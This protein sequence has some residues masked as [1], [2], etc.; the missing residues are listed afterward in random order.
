MLYRNEKE[1]LLLMIPT[2]MSQALSF[3]RKYEGILSSFFF[4]FLFLFLL[5][6]LFLFLFLFLVLFLLFF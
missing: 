1:T 2:C 5:L 4:L 3:T 6:F